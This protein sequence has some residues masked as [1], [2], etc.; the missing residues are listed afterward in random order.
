MPYKLEIN[1]KIFT[2]LVPFETENKKAQEITQEEYDEIIALQQ[3][4]TEKEMQRNEIL[5]QLNE[6]DKKSIR[7]LRNNEND[8]LEA[9]EAQAEALRKELKEI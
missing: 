4:E 1:N 7:A 3:Q 2:A 8:R 9:I 6:L 5:I